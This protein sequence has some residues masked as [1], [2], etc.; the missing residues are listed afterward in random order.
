MVRSVGLRVG[1]GQFRASGGLRQVAGRGFLELRLAANESPSP[2]DAVPWGPIARIRGASKPPT[3][4]HRPPYLK[5]TAEWSWK[6][7][8]MAIG[9]L[10]FVFTEIGL[11]IVNVP[12]LQQ[13]LNPIEFE[14]GR[15]P[16]VAHPYTAYT[17]KP[18]YS[19]APGANYRASHNS[20]GF[21]GEETVWAK[22]E[23]VTRIACVGGSSTYG[24]GVSDNE[25]TWPARLQHLLSSS[26][27]NGEVEVIN[28]GVPGYTTFESLARFALVGVE[29]R[30]DI[31]VVYHSMADVSSALCDSPEPDNTHYRTN[32]PTT[33]RSDIDRLFET[34]RV[35]RLVRSCFANSAMGRYDGNSI[36]SRVS[37]EGVIAGLPPARGFSNFERNIRS[38]IA[39]ANSIDARVVLVS[40]AVD[41]RDLAS[42]IMFEERMLAKNRMDVVLQRLSEELGVVLCDAGPALELEAQRQIKERGSESIFAWEDRLKDS[43]AE[44]LALSIAEAIERIQLSD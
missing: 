21:R 27:E 13:R 20:Y 16:L 17:C 9:A 7:A 26:T 25:H 41:E 28:L 24:E 37:T 1:Q 8:A 35:Y 38:L 40:Q 4:S 19:T 2:S 39:L 33:F 44:I 3:M 32:W 22:P 10:L 42:G 36:A 29:L 12:S 43:G 30:P 34:S 14:E 15:S 18:N 5:S 6:R 11:R 23:G 31:V